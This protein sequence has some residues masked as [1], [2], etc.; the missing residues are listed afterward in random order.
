[1]I[2]DLK[3]TYPLDTDKVAIVFENGTKQQ[4]INVRKVFEIYEYFLRD[5]IELKWFSKYSNT[6]PNISISFGHSSSGAYIGTDGWNA[7]LRNK[8]SI[9]FNDNHVQLSNSHEMRIIGHE[10]FHSIIAAKHQHVEDDLVKRDPDRFY[11]AQDN[12]IKSIMRYR[13][14]GEERNFFPSIQDYVSTI[15][16][17]SYRLLGETYRSTIAGQ[18]IE[19]PVFEICDIHG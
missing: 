1:M 10:F 7:H 8:S 9:N 11:V 17:D 15:Y 13:Q 12:N 2:I 14:E 16:F 3:K 5:K 6:I 4:R 18:I 19:E